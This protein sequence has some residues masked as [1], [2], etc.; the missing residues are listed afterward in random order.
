MSAG[1]VVQGGLG[2]CYFLSAISALATRPERLT[3]VLRAL[4][5]R[6][7]PGSGADGAAQLFMTTSADG[8]GVYCVRLWKGGRW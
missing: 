8:T 6:S 5:A 2:D 1:D 4:A 7:W 3:Q